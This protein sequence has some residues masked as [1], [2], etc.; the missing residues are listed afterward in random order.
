M[1]ALIVSAPGWNKYNGQMSSVPPAKSTRVGALD[2]IRNVILVLLES[3]WV[4]R[5][6]HN[7]VALAAG[8]LFSARCSAS[9]QFNRK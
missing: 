7:A 8:H 4:E 1:A 9:K 3:K 5:C 2:S 6:Q